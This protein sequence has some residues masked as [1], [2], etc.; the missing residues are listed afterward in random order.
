MVS[1]KKFVDYCKDDAIGAAVITK[2]FLLK[3]KGNVRSVHD[4]NSYAD[5][6]F[7]NEDEVTNYDDAIDMWDYL[8]DD[9]CIG[10]VDNDGK[11]HFI[12]ISDE[13]DGIENIIDHSATRLMDSIC[14]AVEEVIN[15]DDE[16]D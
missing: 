11:H 1:E 13:N 4:L 14:E 7:S 12:E 6:E 2:I 16:D 5:Y 9:W 15:P 3:E 8:A 10:V